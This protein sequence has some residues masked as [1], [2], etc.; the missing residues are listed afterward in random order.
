[1]DSAVATLLAADY[2]LYKENITALL[3]QKCLVVT[4]LRNVTRPD[5]ELKVTV[6]SDDHLIGKVTLDYTAT[7]YV[8][9][10]IS[11]HMFVACDGDG[12]HLVNRNSVT[13][14]LS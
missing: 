13:V 10:T 7:Q 2:C 11:A 6:W 12:G 3:F 9:Q 14:C 1:M 4:V 5:A 8:L